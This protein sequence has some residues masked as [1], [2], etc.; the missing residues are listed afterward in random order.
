[1]K[2]SHLVAAL[3]ALS[4]VSVTLA[5]TQAASITA[6]NDLPSPDKEFVQAASMSSSTEIDASKLASK[7]SQDADVKASLTTWKSIIRS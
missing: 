1:M 4:A 2:F 7:Q 6:A 5:Q 3:M